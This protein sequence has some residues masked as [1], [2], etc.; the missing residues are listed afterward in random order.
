MS[1]PIRALI[2]DDEP[3]ARDAICSLVKEDP[4]VTVVGE[5]A[6]GR[7]A[8]E[9]I[10][11]LAPEL[12]FLDIQMPEM[13]GFTMLRRLE[14]A[15]LPAVVFTTAYDRYAVDAFEV[16][17][18]DYLLKPFDDDRFRVA[19][20]RAKGQVRRGRIGALGAELLALLGDV[21]GAPAGARSG[22]PYLR[23]FVTKSGGRVTLIDPEEVDWLEADGDYVTVH[24]GARR[25][26]LRETMKQLA[27]ELD[28]ARFVR[29]TVRPSSTSSGSGNCNRISGGSTS[30]CCGTAPD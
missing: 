1:H 11:A 7:S 12:L 15:D 13:D 24:A 5:G 10:L 29:S 19:L 8:L 27:L 9:A 30:W 20:R 22:G 25:H 14:P 18:V 28:P 4:D 26:L 6:D 23:R 2:V 21:A 3:A 17:A 16:H